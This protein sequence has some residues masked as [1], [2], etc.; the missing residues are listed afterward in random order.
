M[1]LHGTV[2]RKRNGPPRFIAAGSCAATKP[3]RGARAV[4]D[5]ATLLD[6]LW[7][8][9]GVSLGGGVFASQAAGVI[10]D[11]GFGLKVLI[12]VGIA[13]IIFGTIW[14]FGAAIHT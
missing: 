8:L 11:M 5:H 14:F 9:G 1:V 13:G 4:P 10:S 12:T 7:L 6:N 2:L 3:I